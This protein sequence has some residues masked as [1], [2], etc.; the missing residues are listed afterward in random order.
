[1]RIVF[2][3]FIQRSEP[4]LLAE[5]REEGRNGRG[6]GRK[7]YPHLMKILEMWRSCPLL[8]IISCLLWGRENSHLC[9]PANQPVSPEQVAECVHSWDGLI[10]WGWFL[11]ISR[12]WGTLSFLSPVSTLDLL[13]GTRVPVWHDLAPAV[14]ENLQGWADSCEEYENN[15]AS[16]S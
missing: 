7:N 13:T 1:M 10:K 12:G 6:G 11:T 4:T 5:M 3:F 15:K 16:L 9:L 8:I 2:L 14:Q